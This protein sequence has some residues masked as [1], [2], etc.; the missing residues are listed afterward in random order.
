M[1]RKIAFAFGLGALV[2]LSAIAIDTGVAEGSRTNFVHA[3]R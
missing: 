2:I 1:L 3:T